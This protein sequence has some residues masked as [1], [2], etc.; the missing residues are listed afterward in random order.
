MQRTREK[1]RA[2]GERRAGTSNVKEPLNS[3]GHYSRR[4][5]PYD[6]ADPC[7]LSTSQA[8]S[9]LQ[10][11]NFAREA[12]QVPCNCHWLAQSAQKGF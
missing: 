2:H 1:K 12:L 3:S 4:F 5:M 9:I 6:D 11:T 10:A 7:L 8:A